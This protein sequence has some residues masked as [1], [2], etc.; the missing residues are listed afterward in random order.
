MGRT[1]KVDENGE[2]IVTPRKAS[3][4]YL[5]AVLPEGV[6]LDDV[7]L[8]ALLLSLMRLWKH[9]QLIPVQYSKSLSKA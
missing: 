6:T 4:R 7:N 8:V 5:V 9:W 2:K 3:K 1:A